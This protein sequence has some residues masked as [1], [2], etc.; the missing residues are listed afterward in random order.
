MLYGVW[1]ERRLVYIVYTSLNY[2][3]N[4]KCKYQMYILTDHYRLILTKD[5]L[6][7]SSESAPHRDKTTN[8]WGKKK[9]GHKSQSGLDTKTDRPSVVM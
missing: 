9:S 6:D 2:V 5:R 8:F 3:K 4:R 1:T 7:L